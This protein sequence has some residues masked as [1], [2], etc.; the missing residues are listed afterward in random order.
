MTLTWWH[1]GSSEPLK[2]LW[3]QVA[4][5]YHAAHP[6]VSFKVEPI[7]NEQ[8]QTKVPLALQSDDPPD[9][10]QQWG[11]GNLASQIT[12]GKVMDITDQTKGLLGPVA[13]GWQVEGKQY[14]LPYVRHAVGFWYR[15]D[16]FTQAG[17]T[18]PTTMDELTAAGAKLRA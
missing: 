8:F 4:D 2:S 18:V 5:D 1:N 14:G 15:K 9:I 10:Y 16:L 12:S 6:N 7:Q 13:E 3:Q 17:V 11:G